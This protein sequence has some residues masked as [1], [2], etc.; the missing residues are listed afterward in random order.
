[1]NQMPLSSNGRADADMTH[2]IALGVDYIGTNYAGWQQQ[3]HAPS[4]QQVVESAVSRVADQTVRVHCAG[5][6]DAGVHATGQVVHFETLSV[7]PPRA[8]TLGVNTNLPDDV[9]VQWALPVDASFH[10]RFSA[11]AR[12]YR[13]LILRRPVRSALWHHR[14]L[15]THRS[16]N[17]GP[18]RQAAGVLVGRHDFSSFRALACQAKSPVRTVHYLRLIEHG[19]ILEL[20]IGADGFLHHMVR[21]IVGVLLAIGRGDASADWTGEL[22]S[23]R[24][25]R[26]GGI[27]APAHGLY[28]ARVDYP[29]N[30]G[31]PTSMGDSSLAVI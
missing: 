16:L 26:R 13:Y 8:W 1:M 17:L 25:R 24:D 4:V 18:M 11:Q 14:A 3:R 21:N 27:T 28:L 10:A 31:L 9:A 6:T 2:R 15:W 30:Y 20:A 7:R 12:H 19:P 29:S 22:L 5:R 23:L